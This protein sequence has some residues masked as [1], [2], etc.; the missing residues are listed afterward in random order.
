MVVSM[1][2]AK[3]REL[4]EAVQAHPD[5]LFDYN[6][7]GPIKHTK[8]TCGCAYHVAIAYGVIRKGIYFGDE[9]YSL[10]GLDCRE[11]EYLFA[12]N[13][14]RGEPWQGKKGKE[15]FFKR[16]KKLTRGEL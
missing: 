9:M 12:S 5:H 4:K 15:T 2:I 14:I 11:G 3:L 16:L 10:F 7:V 13:Y 1:D 6:D 8:D